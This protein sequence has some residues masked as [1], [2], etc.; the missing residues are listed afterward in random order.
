[1]IEPNPAASIIS[2]TVPVEDESDSSAVGIHGRFVPGTTLVGRYRIVSLLG[3]GG[4]GEVYRAD[5]LELGQ[6]VA[7]KFLPR[8]VWDRA[9]RL[10]RLR[11]EV[12]I[13]RQISHPN[14][15]RVYDIGRIDDEHFLSMEF[16]DGED[17]A[18]ELRRLGRPAREKALEMARQLCAGLAAAHNEGILH[19]DLK[20]ANVMIDGRGRVR[21]TDF[22]LAG[23]ADELEEHHALSGTPAYMAP[24]QL[25]GGKL[26]ARS[27][28]YSLGLILFELFSGVRYRDEV[29]QAGPDSA[30]SSGQ[31]DISL[32][33]LVP[34]LEPGIEKVV[35]W[36]LAEDPAQRPRSVL[37]VA[38]ALPGSDPMAAALE[39]GEI[40]SPE[41]VAGARGAEELPVRTA[42]L[43]LATTLVLM[44][45]AAHLSDRIG[46]TRVAMPS[47]TPMAL[48]ESASALLRELGYPASGYRAYGLRNEPGFVDYLHRRDLP[49]SLQVEMPPG[50]PGPISFWYRESPGRMIP[51]YRTRGMAHWG[52]SVSRSGV[53]LEDPPLT[54][55]GMILVRLSGEGRLLE[56]GTKPPESMISNQ[57]SL[58][59]DYS[60][61][62]RAAGV[63]ETLTTQIP[64][65]RRPDHHADQLDEWKGTSP[66][67]SSLDII[68][69]T[70]EG[71]PSS[72]RVLGPWDVAAY[73]EESGR[74]SKSERVKS[75]MSVLYYATFIGSILLGIRNLRRGRADRHGATRLAA[76]VFALKMLTWS[77]SEGMPALFVFR[78]LDLVILSLGD[79]LQSAVRY[80]FYYVAI[81]PYARRLWPR[82]LI[83]WS[84]ALSGRLRD[85][86]VGRE[87]LF[88]TCFGT[89]WFFVNRLG[90]LIAARQGVPP[91]LSVTGR[92]LRPALMPL[93]GLLQQAIAAVFLTLMAATLLVLLLV[94]FKSRWMVFVFFVAI[95]TPI[96]ALTTNHWIH[97]LTWAALFA[98]AVWVFSAFGVLAATAAVFVYISLERFPV[99]LDLSVWYTGAALLPLL[100]CSALALYGFY[101]ALAGR[102]MIRDALM[103][104]S[105]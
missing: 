14:V 101:T 44:L 9:D 62:F 30:S 92:W 32:S 90:V 56:L 93:S 89:A 16:V 54:V 18:S 43:L 94:L 91:D 63:D 97:W 12:R 23:F 7:L 59:P 33:S 34:D 52:E 53:T 99:T 5:D 96:G 35:A 46:T 21:I 42:W 81:E 10:A 38:A 24:E 41:M 82:C 25:M 66:T 61:L 17:L 50:T 51:R 104:P 65:T 105:A 55:S 3:K 37:S 15:C 98:S 70:A 40:P 29:T 83:G 84:R 77:L 47:K 71:R 60:A 74:G 2:Q 102:P 75:I 58:D 1:M 95:W 69:A 80:W 22:G 76:I 103:R 73:D 39:A 11:Q 86:Q 79:A 48:A 67:T 100:A 4:M 64:P 13:A 88:G 8:Q 87:L 36:C 49:T 26:T 28:I 45:V 20:P 19:R 57:R 78:R 27:D 68:A 85:A 72:F 6:S 31:T